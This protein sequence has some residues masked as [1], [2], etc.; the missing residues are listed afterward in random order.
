MP[1]LGMISVT[2]GMKQ[3]TQVSKG[4]KLGVW[5]FVAWLDGTG[6]SCTCAVDG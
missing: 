1:G 5:V 6:M 2:Q 3:K 4:E